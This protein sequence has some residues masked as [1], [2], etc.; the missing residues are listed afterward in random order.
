M[1]ART[2]TQILSSR[3]QAI[4][5]FIIFLPIMLVF[6]GIIVSISSAINGS[7]NQ[8]KSTRGFLYS[9][10]KG[11]PNIPIRELVQTNFQDSGVQIQGMMAQLYAEKLS[12]QGNLRPYATCYKVP[13][14]GQDDG[15]ACDDVTGAND[16]SP[17]IRIKTGYG[18]C[19]ATYLTD[20]NGLIRIQ[21]F[22]SGTNKGC[23]ALTNP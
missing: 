16:S 15:E 19:G 10:I 13:L 3:G 7:I 8:Q 18:L 1:A 20:Q 5:E 9:T 4:F 12:T 17:F 11:N 23:L 22:L 2:S 6:Y 21:Y 14:Y